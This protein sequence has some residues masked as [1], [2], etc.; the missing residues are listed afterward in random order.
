[1]KGDVW[2]WCA[3]KLVVQIKRHGRGHGMGG[4]VRGAR[5]GG[6]VAGRTKSR[7]WA[8]VFIWRPQA[9][10]TRKQNMRRVP[11]ARLGITSRRGTWAVTLE[12]ASRQE[13][14]IGGTV[15]A[16]QW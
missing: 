14:W 3:G 1:M 4:M 11:S 2:K 6:E 8:A 16:G 9:T 10:T 12:M 13:D 15:D 7:G 5:D